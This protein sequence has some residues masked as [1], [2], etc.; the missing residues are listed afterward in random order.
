M[1]INKIYE[2]FILFKGISGELG[3]Y[4]AL[5]S[6]VQVSVE[7]G[8]LSRFE[9]LPDSALLNTVWYKQ[10]VNPLKRYYL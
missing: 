10:R 9:R 8:V 5:K 6:G 2:C 4:F 1:Q 7:A 3:C